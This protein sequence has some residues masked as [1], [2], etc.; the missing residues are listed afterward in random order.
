LKQ[1]EHEGG[2]RERAGGHDYR[3]LVRQPGFGGARGRLD[4]DVTQLGGRPL[5]IELKP[6]NRGPVVGSLLFG[7][8][9]SLTGMCP[10]P[11][12]VNAGEGKV[13]ALA[14]LAGALVGA[15]VFG[16]LRA[17]RTS[18]A[19]RPSRP[20]RTAAPSR[21]RRADGRRIALAPAGRHSR[22]NAS[23]AFPGRPPKAA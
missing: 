17:S 15:G 20:L 16:A 11:I 7:V 3:P 13:Y 22:P 9:W 18:S 1:Q 23:S 8:G 6:L 12:L 21:P 10:G 5:A 4:A 14:V 19:F 2:G